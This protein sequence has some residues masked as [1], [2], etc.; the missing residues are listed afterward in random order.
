[1]TPGVETPVMA[2]LKGQAGGDDRVAQGL[3]LLNGYAH[4]LFYQRMLAGSQRLARQ[5]GVKLIGHANDYRV[6]LR[7][8]QHIGVAGEAASGPVHRSH[9]R[10]QVGR[11]LAQRVQLGIAPLATGLQMRD[12][13]DRPCA[14]HAYAKKSRFFFDCH[15]HLLR[16]FPVRP[17][18]PDRPRHETRA[19][20]GNS[21][22]A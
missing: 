9:A 5:L 16:R 4:R 2:H 13:R 22:K 11:S 17:P 15:D 7:V 8:G 21:R 10:Q 1:M 12:L 3:A 20:P 19:R 6:Q 18:A 14:Q